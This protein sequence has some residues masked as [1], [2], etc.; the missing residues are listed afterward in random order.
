MLCWKNLRRKISLN[1]FTTKNK[2]LPCHDHV[3]S[4][5][6]YFCKI[7]IIYI[8]YI[9]WSPGRR[10]FYNSKYIKKEIWFFSNHFVTKIFSG[11]T[12]RNLKNKT[13]WSSNAC[14]DFWNHNLKQGFFSFQKFVRV[15]ESVIASKSG[16]ILKSNKMCCF[17]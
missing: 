4:F 17:S 15:L 7:S 14:F 10:L 3:R 5:L 12:T 1:L 6:R 2:N 13:F 9:L 11:W 16:N 8:F